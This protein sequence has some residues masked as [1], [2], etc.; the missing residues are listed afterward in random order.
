ML[1]TS[2]KKFYWICTR[3]S[4]K[5]N[6]RGRTYWRSPRNIQVE[7]CCLSLLTQHV[8]FIEIPAYLRCFANA[9]C[10]AAQTFLSDNDAER[11]WSRLS[12]HVA[13]Q[14]KGRPICQT[15]SVYPSNQFPSSRP[16]PGETLY[17]LFI[18][19]NKYNSRVSQLTPSTTSSLRVFLVAIVRK[20]CPCRHFRMGSLWPALTIIEGQYLQP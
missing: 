6:N 13:S 20:T 11:T 3:R 17:F 2:K 10:A 14:I 18:Y 16:R 5:H 4:L 9:A 12:A 7:W 1:S 19:K 8:F 15:I